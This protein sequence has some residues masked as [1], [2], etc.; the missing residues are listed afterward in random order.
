M[1]TGQAEQGMSPSSHWVYRK[2]YRGTENNQEP[3]ALFL[4]G[5]PLLRAVAA[6]G[7]TCGCSSAHH[8]IS[9]AWALSDHLSPC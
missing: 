8:E 9:H 7:T 6:L 4:L 5:S 3:N 1:T 2:T